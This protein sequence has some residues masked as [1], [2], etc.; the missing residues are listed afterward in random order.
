[1]YE[2][3]MDQFTVDLFSVAVFFYGPF[4]QI[5]YVHDCLCVYSIVLH[6]QHIHYNR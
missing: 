1:M 3:N 5:P 6:I 4:Y 2:Y